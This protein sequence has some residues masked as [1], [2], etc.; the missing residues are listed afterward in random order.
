MVVKS[1][2]ANSTLFN[3]PLMMAAESTF[4]FLESKLALVES[5]FDNASFITCTFL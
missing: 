3:M 4:G 2:L 5:L 1:I